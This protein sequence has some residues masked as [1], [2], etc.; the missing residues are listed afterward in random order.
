MNHL[1]VCQQV[2]A[3]NCLAETGGLRTMIIHERSMRRNKT[4]IK[5]WS[6]R[7]NDVSID[8]VRHSGA[9]FQSNVHNSSSASGCGCHSVLPSGD[10]S[11]T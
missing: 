7:H 10:Y 9:T 5:N 11:L 4:R 6:C 8:Q 2:S 1:S 3:G